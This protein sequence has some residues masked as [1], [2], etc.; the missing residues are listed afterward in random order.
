MSSNA[1]LP[2]LLMD[3]S[4]NNEPL[5]MF[6]AM[7]GNQQCGPVHIGDHFAAPAVTY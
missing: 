5:I 2:L 1:L 4:S 3:S 7:M 6:M